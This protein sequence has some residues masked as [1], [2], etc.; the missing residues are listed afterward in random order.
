[1]VRANRED[2]KRNPAIEAFSRF[3][4]RLSSTRART[5]GRTYCSPSHARCCCCVGSMM[6]KLRVPPQVWPA[7]ELSG[8]N[9]CHVK[10][11]H[12]RDTQHTSVFR[13]SLALTK[14]MH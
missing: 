5:F 8:P 1:M 14:T 6:V 2:F 13:L 9:I 3:L 4:R 11:S 10:N 12:S 7:L